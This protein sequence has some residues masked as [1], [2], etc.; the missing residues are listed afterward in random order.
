MWSLDFSRKTA[1]TNLKPEFDN[2]CT[3]VMF[4]GSLA[5]QLL[6][7]SLLC[8]TTLGN[9]VQGTLCSILRLLCPQVNRGEQ[10]YKQIIISLH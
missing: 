1:G 7:I 10:D 5:L 2:G 4:W 8:A 6:T 9:R 3:T